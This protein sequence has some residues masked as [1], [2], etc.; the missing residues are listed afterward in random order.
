M[1]ETQIYK[2]TDGSRYKKNECTN[3]LK[4]KYITKTKTNKSIE[5]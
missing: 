1:Q 5:S 2:S 4:A 3:E